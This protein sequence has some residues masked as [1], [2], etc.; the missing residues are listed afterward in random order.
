MPLAFPAPARASSAHPSLQQQ[1]RQ[2][3]SP[4]PT[5][6]R[7]VETGSDAGSVPRAGPFGV[8]AQ[9]HRTY[10]M[11]WYASLVPCARRPRAD[12]TNPPSRAVPP[13]RV[14]D[15][16]PA[17]SPQSSTPRQIPTTPSCSRACTRQPS[18]FATHG[19][20]SSVGTRSPLPLRPAP[21]AV[22]PAPRHKRDGIARRAAHVRSPS[23]RTT[24][25]TSRRW[26]L[27]RTAA[28]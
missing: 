17:Q 25:S 16:A 5:K 2:R 27:S 4:S 24:S 20:T 22:R 9:G 14:S 11:Q 3:D 13:P 15:R 19:T 18:S 1:H 21:P 23:R 7:R 26:R 6:K 12:P 8:D 28:S 10:G